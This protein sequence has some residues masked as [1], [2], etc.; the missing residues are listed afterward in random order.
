MDWHA[1][2]NEIQSEYFITGTGTHLWLDW[3][4]SSTVLTWRFDMLELGMSHTLTRTA[5]VRQDDKRRW[6]VNDRCTGMSVEGAWDAVFDGHCTE[7]LLEI[8]ADLELEH[9]RLEQI[10][11]THKNAGTKRGHEARRQRGGGGLTL[12]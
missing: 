8:H 11:F 2:R 10:E 6:F 5:R 4:S 9:T 1:R 7:F 12:N 3:D